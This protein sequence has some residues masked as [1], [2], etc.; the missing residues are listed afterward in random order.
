MNKIT[1]NLLSDFHANINFESEKYHTKNSKL[2]FKLDI[3]Y[4]IQTGYIPV[5]LVLQGL[6]RYCTCSGPSTVDDYDKNCIV[7]TTCISNQLVLG[8]VGQY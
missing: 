6:K 7:Y 1:L 2:F 4:Q 8:N 5:R 3:R